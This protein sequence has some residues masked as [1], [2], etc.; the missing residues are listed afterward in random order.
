V[1]FETYADRNLDKYL[2]GAIPA[3]GRFQ[4]LKGSYLTMARNRSVNP[5]IFKYYAY[6]GDLFP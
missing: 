5:P 3:D 1:K 6:R 4:V 2:L